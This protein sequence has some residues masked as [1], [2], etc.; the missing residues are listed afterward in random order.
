MKVKCIINEFGKIP[1]HVYQGLDG[2]NENTT[3]QIDIGDTSVVYGI[4]RTNGCYWY[5]VHPDG[6]NCPYYYPQYFFEIV[7]YRISREWIINI[8]NNPDDE[9]SEL[10]LGFETLFEPYFY[11]RLLEDDPDVIEKFEQ[12]K[13]IMDLE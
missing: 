7:D 2:Y 3:A 12:A 9:N 13:K 11:G 6:F 5:L 1:A 10:I 8:N 4:I